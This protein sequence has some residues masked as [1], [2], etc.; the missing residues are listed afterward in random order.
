MLVTFFFIN[1]LA[2]VI[3]PFSYQNISYLGSWVFVL[4]AGWLTLKKLDAKKES[5]ISNVVALGAKKESAISNVVLGAFI[6]GGTSIALGVYGSLIINPR[7]E[8]AILWVL[9][10]PVG[11]IIGAILGLIVG[12]KKSN[13]WRI[14][15]SS[16]AIL[17]VIVVAGGQTYLSW[18]QSKTSS[19]IQHTSDLK[20]RN[21]TLRYL[22]VRALSDNDLTQLKRFKN[23]YG[24]NFYRGWA[25][26]EAK[27]TDAGLKI[28]YEMNLP[29]LGALSLGHCSNITDEGM[30]YISVIKTLKSL[31][32]VANTQI[33]DLGLFYLSKSKSINSMDLRGCTGITDKGLSYLVNMRSLRKLR[34][35]G[36]TNI[37]ASGIDEL[38]RFLPNIS[39]RKDDEE[40]A[41][42]LLPFEEKMKV[43]KQPA[44][45]SISLT[46]EEF[47]EIKKQWE[48]PLE[49]KDRRKG[50]RTLYK[51]EQKFQ[52]LFPED[53]NIIPKKTNDIFHYSAWAKV[54]PNL[55][56]VIS[57]GE[58]NDA[59][60]ADA[61][62]H[63]STR[64][65]ANE[66][67]NVICLVKND[68]TYLYIA[69]IIKNNDYS[70]G[71]YADS[72]RILFNKDSNTSSTLNKNHGDDVIVVKAN[73]KISDA[74]Y[75]S[76]SPQIG[77][78]P[79]MDRHDGGTN[80]VDAA[81]EHSNPLTGNI[82]DYV[83]EL[84]HPLQGSDKAHDI[85]LAKGDTVAFQI[86][87]FDWMPNGSTI[88]ASHFP[89]TGYAIITI[90][91][92]E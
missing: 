82:G 77:W 68:N 69:L 50:R 75:D 83:F 88:K 57:A 70:A 23:L 26:R 61:T 9:F 47:N 46:L 62:W 85:D 22:N 2:R 91:G 30:V 84:R 53:L 86:T 3:I 78:I 81:I 24:L 92:S 90:K 48:Q 41:F 89:N 67:H 28:L 4:I 71:W 27:L 1:M 44:K 56:G 43:L 40:W 52:K 5:A 37:T 45:K 17:S 36:C 79:T 74:F 39:I 34:L 63:I 73:G 14:L 59:D 54:T 55:D 10:G 29:K 76:S 87:F 18:H 6:L 66:S 72:I 31:G 16:C 13:A 25:A 51:K 64:N 58:W 38:K 42:E 33:T 21:N 11:F 80:D 7:N 35:G 19:F 15:L 12:T 65:D 32:L 49:Y 20:K 8:Q 60:K